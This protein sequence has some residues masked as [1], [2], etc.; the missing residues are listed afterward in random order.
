MVDARIEIG[1]LGDQRDF[2]ALAAGVRDGHAGRDPGAF[3]HRV[4][5]DH[6]ALDGPRE[7]ERAALQLAIGLFFTGRKEAIEIDVQLLRGGGLPHSR[8]VA[9]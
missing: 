8:T 1:P 3:G 5:G 4:G 6:A 2:R 9:K 7:R